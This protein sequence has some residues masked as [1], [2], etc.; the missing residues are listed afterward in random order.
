VAGSVPVSLIVVRELT[1]VDE[2]DPALKA[3]ERLDLYLM[4]IGWAPSRRAAKELI[5]S[6]CV[7]VNRRRSHKG[8]VV[9]PGDNI[10]VTAP[11]SAIELAPNPELKIEILFEDAALVVVN[12]PGLIP[13]HPLRSDERRTIMNAAIAMYPEI[14]IAGDKALEGGLVHRLDNGTSGALMIA[15]TPEAFSAM[16]DA[17]RMGRVAR[18]YRAL[19]AG[20]LDKPIE[21]ATPIAH[22]PK[23]TRKM[24]VIDPYGSS[25]HAIGANRRHQGSAARPAATIAEPLSHHGDFTLVSVNPRT[26]RR[27]QI[28]VHL[29]SIGKP[30]AGDILYGGPSLAGLA[31]GRFWLHL[32]SLEFNSP[33]SG[34][35]KAD[36]PLAK[37]LAGALARLN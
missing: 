17:I 34:R 25:L 27:H 20:R 29:A 11:S 6:G 5:A 2:S 35:V 22:H 28:R 21:I 4:R 31:L 10:E 12:K 24:V 23:N 8:S 32:A 1:I 33:A 30:I 9:V 16:R 7:I 3:G 36:A 19:V 14:A 37:D 18:H 15:R 13:C 26:G